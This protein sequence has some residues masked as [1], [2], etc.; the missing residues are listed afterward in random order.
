M[1]DL[2]R[3]LGVPQATKLERVIWGV[4]ACSATLTF[5]FYVIEHGHP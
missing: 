2:W 1:K 5:V 4:G 3:R